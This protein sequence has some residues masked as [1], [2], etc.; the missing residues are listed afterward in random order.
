MIKTVDNFYQILF[1]A[2]WSLTGKQNLQQMTVFQFFFIHLELRRELRD[3]SGRKQGG[4]ISVAGL[5]VVKMLMCSLEGGYTSKG[6]KR[7]IILLSFQITQINFLLK[8]LYAW[9][10]LPTM[11]CPLGI[12]DQITLW[13]SLVY[14]T[15]Q[16]YYRILSFVHTGCNTN[17]YSA[18]KRLMGIVLYIRKYN[19]KEDNSAFSMNIWHRY[20]FYNI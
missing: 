4:K 7:R 8:K 20:T 2:H 9:S 17:Y 14:W 16:I 1:E 13:G 11:T 3:E 5:K 12:N 19:I 18:E 6:L 10:S 15:C